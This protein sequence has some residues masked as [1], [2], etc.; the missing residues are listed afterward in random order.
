MF[1]K[2]RQENKTKS[3]K[4][5]RQFPQIALPKVDETL[6]PGA[7]VALIANDDSLKGD[8]V[9]Q[10]DVLIV[11]CD[12]KGEITPDRIA[13]VQLQE[14]KELVAYHLTRNN[15]QVTLRASNRRYKALVY[16]LAQIKIIGVVVG[17]YRALASEA[18]CNVFTLQQE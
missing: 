7:T 2:T 10:G 8:G 6:N 12:C 17:F 5:G 18:N 3:K 4:G 1:R 16:D 9:Q 15:Y 13:I 11:K 14:T